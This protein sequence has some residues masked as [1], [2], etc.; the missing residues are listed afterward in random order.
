[1][2]A[3]LLVNAFAIILFSAAC[4]GTCG[5]FI[6]FLITKIFNIDK[7]NSTIRKMLVFFIIILIIDILLYGYLVIFGS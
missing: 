5:I 4:T 7:L 1:M 6:L 3:S 2:N